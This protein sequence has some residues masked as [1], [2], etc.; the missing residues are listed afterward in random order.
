MK[1]KEFALKAAQKAGK[2]LLQKF[3]H[4]VQKEV[5][6]KDKYEV[7]TRADF[8]AEEAILE[9]IRQKYPQHDILTEEAGRLDRQAEYLWIIDPLD[10]TTNYTIGNPLFSIS[11]GLAHHQKLTIGVIYAPFLHELWVAEKGQGA[12]LNKRKIKVSSVRKI[13]DAFLLFCHGNKK[14]DIKRTIKLFDR[15]KL[16]ARH[17]RQLGSAAIELASVATGRAESIAIPGINTWDA[18]AGVLL[19]REAGGK[20]TDFQ[21]KEWD[22]DSPD[23][24]ATNGKI[25][26]ELLK[27]IKGV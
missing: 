16:P 26:E 22:L 4:L 25:H 23:M 14:Q 15:L 5:N 27:L 19:V 3:N 18:A 1:E 13:K 10:G 17:L 6:L 11:I 24:L 8:E 7:V 12:W 2:I 9:V 21:G 20:V